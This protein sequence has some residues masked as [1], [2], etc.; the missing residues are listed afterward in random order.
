MTHT[1][2]LGT[3]INPDLQVET[4]GIH[5]RQRTTVAQNIM[6]ICGQDLEQAY[7]SGSEIFDRQVAP[8]SLVG[9]A[10][11]A[12]AQHRRMIL[13]PDTVW[14]T[15]ER[16]LATHILENAEELRP[17]FVSHQGKKFIEIRRD[18]FVR[19]Q[20]NDWEGCFDEFSEKIGEHIGKKKDL[21]VSEFSTT[22][23]LQRVASE[24][25][26][27]EA[28]SKYFD[29]GM[30]TRCSI[31]S[32]T[33]EGSIEDWEKIKTKVHAISEFGLSWWTDRLIPVV[34]ELIRSAKGNP[35]LDFWRSWY[36]QGG[37]SGGPFI[38]GHINTFYPYLK[39][40][41]KIV[42]N[43]FDHAY[44]PTL[45]NFTKGFSRVPFVWDYYDTKY[46]MNFVGGIVGIEAIE[47]GAVRGAFGWAVHDEAV[48]LSQ[49]PLE[50]MVKD[51]IIHSK[52][53]VGKLKIADAEEW[54]PGDRKLSE[55]Q[56]EWEKKGLQKHRSWEISSFYV[57]TE[58]KGELIYDRKDK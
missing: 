10:H 18:N 12:F 14:L 32:V 45:S 5:E 16:G 31:P 56:I 30:Q 8:P 19:G 37:G 34:D 17:Q 24:I 28:M 57:K 7:D 25:V 36:K 20:K 2:Q 42:R 47:G 49:Y 43:D 15:I 54:E 50:Y 21:I 53:D 52:D 29:Y 39:E 22:G 44:G 38:T 27:M 58:A 23:V 35:D 48:N 51:M 1:F 9:L 6:N 55:V 11:I 13:D 40:Y 41:K 33:L 3:V 26:L 4:G 46:P